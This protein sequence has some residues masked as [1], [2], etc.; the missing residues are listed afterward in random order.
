M[1]WLPSLQLS[2]AFVWFQLYAPVQ[3]H[4]SRY[5]SSTKPVYALLPAVTIKIY[6]DIDIGRAAI[7]SAWENCVECSQASA[8]GQS[9]A[10]QEGQVVCLACIVAV[11]CSSA[12]R[13][14]KHWV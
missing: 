10:P 7:V 11:G 5:R 4:Q 6:L 12:C 2:C 13:Q 9:Q 1:L 8:V 3:M 14:Y